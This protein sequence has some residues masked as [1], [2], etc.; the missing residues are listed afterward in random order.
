MIITKS[1]LSGW[2]QTQL[3]I[4]NKPLNL[5]VEFQHFSNADIKGIFF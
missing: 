5:F 3:N 2:Y 4:L 1:Q